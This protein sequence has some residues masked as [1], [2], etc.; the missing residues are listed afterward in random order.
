M[1]FEFYEREE[2]LLDEKKEMKEEDYK[3]FYMIGGYG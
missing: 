1:E 2:L 3:V